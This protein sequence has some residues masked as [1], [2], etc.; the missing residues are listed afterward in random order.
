MHHG[1]IWVESKLVEGNK[2]S[3]ILPMASKIFKKYIK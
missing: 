3:F 2:F 1:K